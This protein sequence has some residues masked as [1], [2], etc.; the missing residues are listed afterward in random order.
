M[1]FGIYDLIHF[2]T[3]GIPEASSKKPRVDV[4]FFPSILVCHMG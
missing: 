3:G 2:A 1:V 4:A